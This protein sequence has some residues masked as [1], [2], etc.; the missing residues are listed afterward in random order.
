MVQA[1]FA[2][3]LLEQAFDAP[4]HA[5]NARQPGHINVLPRTFAFEFL[6]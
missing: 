1:H 6:G 2:V 3:R 4:A 5:R